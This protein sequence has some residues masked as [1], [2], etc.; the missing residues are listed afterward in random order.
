MIENNLVCFPSLLENYTLIKNKNNNF[1]IKQLWI[2][3]L[4]SSD[5]ELSVFNFLFTEISLTKITIKTNEVIMFK[6]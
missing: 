1:F 4:I 5:L 2:S 3:Q 6:Y